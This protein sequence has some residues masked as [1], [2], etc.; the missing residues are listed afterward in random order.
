MAIKLP[1]VACPKPSVL[2]WCD[3]SIPLDARAE[4]LLS[5]LR[6]DELPGLL[7]NDLFGGASSVDRL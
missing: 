6:D 4:L 1:A 3:P 7:A 5:A 2:P